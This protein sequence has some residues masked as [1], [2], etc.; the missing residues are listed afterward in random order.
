MCG[1][2]L[3]DHALE[4]DVVLRAPVS[5]CQ[6]GIAGD[7]I[8]IHR[9]CKC[10]G[11][12]SGPADRDRRPPTEAADSVLAP[13]PQDRVEA[14]PHLVQG[15]WVR[16]VR[17][18]NLALIGGT[19]DLREFLFGSERNR[20]AIVRPVLL[21]LQQGRCF[22]CNR[23]IVGDTAHVD[24]FVAWARHPVDLA[25]DFVLADS[26]CNGK[27]RDRLPACEHLAAWTEGNASERIRTCEQRTDEAEVDGGALQPVPSIL[28][29]FTNGS[30]VRSFVFPC[31]FPL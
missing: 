26:K 14:F 9:H 8:P 6:D 21:D 13:Q 12:T 16:Y 1:C 10:V 19:A 18:Q 11:A 3:W 25:H 7:A 20:V 23:G 28:R 24:H 2:S 31:D 27:K 4:L 15:A 5:P 29:S 30:G 22:Y 17:Q